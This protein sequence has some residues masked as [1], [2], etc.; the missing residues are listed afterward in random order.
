MVEDLIPHAQMVV[1]ITNNGYIKRMPL[2]DYEIQRRGGRGLIGVEAKESDIAK[3][4]LVADTHDYLLFFT[5]KG[6]VH[7]LKVYA[8]PEAGRYS[9]GK[10]IVNLLELGE[11]KVRAV[12][13]V[14]KFT[15]DEFLV[16]AT[17]EGI[18]KKT[19]LSDYGNP[20]KGGIIA[21][22]LREGDDLM[23][24]KRTDGKQKLLLATRDGMSV[25]FEESDVRDTGRASSGVIGI[26]MR[27]GDSLVGMEVAE[28][29]AT[30]LT[31]CEKGFGKRTPATEYRVQARG[32]LGVINI[33][34]T[35]RNGGVVAIRAVKDSDEIMLVN[36]DG[37]II[38]VPASEISVIG[39]NTQGVRIMKVKEGAKV[40]AMEVIAKDAQSGQPQEPPSP[41]SCAG[42]EAPAP[43]SPPAPEQP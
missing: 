26:R 2:S 28:D 4:L 6:R 41:D 20:R 38:R 33:Q 30:I 32:G 42:A 9:A 11:E 27:E 10:A 21:I 25:R 29:G 13:P 22:N 12:I 5:D 36:S 7:W 40:V 14:S 17:R 35:D 34:A 39:R 16:F 31:V 3:G 23:D 18:V 24:V 1:T 43:E 8:V 15:E 37:I 19:A